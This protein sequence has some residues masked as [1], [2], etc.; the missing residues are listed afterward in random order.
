MLAE[1]DPVELE[2]KLLEGSDDEGHVELEGDEPFFNQSNLK[3][4]SRIVSADMKRLVSDLIVEEKEETVQPCGNEV[5]MGRIHNRLDSWKGVEFDTIDMMIGLDFKKE[6]DSWSKFNNQVQETA[7]EI[8][9][10]IFVQIIEE[11]T[12]DLGI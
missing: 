11:L 12:E 2:R 1:L 3:Y 9:V 6:L 5:V 4:D 7:A 10:A 8:E